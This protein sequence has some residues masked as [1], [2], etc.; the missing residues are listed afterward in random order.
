MDLMQSKK[1]NLLPTDKHYQHSTMV[2]IEFGRLEQVL[3]WC[4]KLPNLWVWNLEEWTTVSSPGQYKFY[5][6]SE[7]DLLAFI[8]RWG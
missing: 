2:A 8:L 1:N 7:K 6:K 4:K 3:E 5:F